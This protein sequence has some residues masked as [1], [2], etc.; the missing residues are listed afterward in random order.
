MPGPLYVVR[1]AESVLGAKNI[2]NGDPSVENPLTERGR[3]QAGGVAATLAGVDLELCV[4]TGFRRT[5]ETADV[6]LEGRDVPRRVIFDLNDPR[7]G[8]YEGQPFPI[9]AEWMDG[10][11]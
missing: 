3:G 1:H 9:S 8:D 10:S 5:Q 7:Q 11:G 2:V 6:I 4:T